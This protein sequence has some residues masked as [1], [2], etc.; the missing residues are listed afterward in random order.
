MGQLTFTLSTCAEYY[1]KLKQDCLYTFNTY[2]IIKN[3]Y[4]KYNKTLNSL[5]LSL[6]IISIQRAALCAARSR[7]A[8]SIKCNLL[9]VLSCVYA[10]VGSVRVVYIQR[11][12]V[13]KCL[14]PWVNFRLCIYTYSSIVYRLC[15]MSLWREN[16]IRRH[17]AGALIMEFTWRRV[18][19][20][21][22]VLAL[23]LAPAYTLY[24][25]I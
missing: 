9:L 23:F 3:Y 1:V 17:T 19:T 15:A 4:F 5:S 8:A 13:Y 18:L 25:S 21:R 22:T 24:Y 11:W 6:Y 16:A 2:K 10:P 20:A 14:S 12:K 7:R